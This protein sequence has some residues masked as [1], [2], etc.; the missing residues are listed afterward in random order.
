M[1]NESEA[2]YQRLV[3]EL[4]RITEERDI[5]LKE[6]NHFDVASQ[7]S[8]WL[9]KQYLQQ[10]NEINKNFR[11]LLKEQDDHQELYNRVH[12][13][14]QRLK[15]QYSV[16]SQKPTAA[17]STKTAAKALRASEGRNAELQR[18][19]VI[20]Q[21]DLRRARRANWNAND[22]ELSEVR[23]RV[24]KAQELIT[25]REN[26]LNNQQARF[27]MLR[28]QSGDEKAAELTRLIE[29]IRMKDATISD[30]MAEKV[31]VTRSRNEYKQR[32]EALEV[33]NS[34]TLMEGVDETGAT[35]EDT[36]TQGLQ[37]QQDISY[38]DAIR[39][40]QATL[41]E[42]KT[43]LEEENS[44]TPMEGVDETGDAADDTSTQDLLSLEQD[45][46]R[47]HHPRP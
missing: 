11:I 27:D 12:N 28:S 29:E 34:S 21:Q 31:Y 14:A 3:A 38:H 36:S 19:L 4:A 42:D 41:G 13:D 15:A 35:V 16:T 5:C 47:C 22:E 43:N 2:N 46:S 26:N 1:S 9:Q 23:A 8:E 10:Y 32:L 39:G 30:L 17:E 37:L 20:M 45:Q 7:K 24:I 33:F 18:Q 40:D 44:H 6:R 25:E